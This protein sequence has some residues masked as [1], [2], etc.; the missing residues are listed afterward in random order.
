MSMGLSRR[1]SAL[2]GP[3]QA[4]RACI[5]KPEASSPDEVLAARNDARVRAGLPRLS[6][7]EVAF[8]TFRGL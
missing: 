3:S 2:E 6:A 4:V 5:F 7:K 1:V 8:I